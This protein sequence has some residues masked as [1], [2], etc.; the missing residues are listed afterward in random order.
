[1]ERQII[2]HTVG[3]IAVKETFF[4]TSLLDKLLENGIRGI[5]LPPDT[6]VIK[7]SLNP[8]DPIIYYMGDEVFRNST[9]EFLTELRDMCYENR[10]MLI[11][12]GGVPEYQAAVKIIPKS[13]IV[14]WFKR[15]I[16]IDGLLKTLENCYR[17]VI[18][19]TGKKHILIVDD[20]TTYMRMM[21]E[22][23]KDYYIINMLT[24]G[25]QLMLWLKEKRPDLILLDYEMPGENGAEVYNTLLEHEEYKDIPV[26]FLT[27]IQKKDVV[28][29][30]IE[31]NPRGY[32]LKSLN[33]DELLERLEEF[34]HNENHK[35]G[36]NSQP[37]GPGAS[38][39]YSPAG[40]DSGMSEI[41]K[42]LAE[43]NMR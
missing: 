41:D 12:I 36:G 40:D 4:L 14:D 29:N 28:M 35:A 13:A 23:L 43:M 9:G 39:S 42:L 34:F 38:G 21:H 20:D 19:A 18:K 27:G 17:G 32:L 22:T 6:N 26:I 16:D 1:M 15:P 5:M 10:K 25:K 24:S 8:R 3:I 11:L 33:Q 2:N 30:A 7:R 31:L 37:G